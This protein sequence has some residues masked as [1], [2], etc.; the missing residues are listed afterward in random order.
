MSDPV[1][2]REGDLVM[3]TRGGVYVAWVHRAGPRDVVIQPCDPSIEDRR[4][5]IDEITAVY[6]LAG[7]PAAAPKRLRPSPRQLRLDDERPSG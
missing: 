7:R 5:S 4:V 1:E 2:I 3:V 6:R